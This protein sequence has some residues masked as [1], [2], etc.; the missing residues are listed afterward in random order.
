MKLNQGI[1]SITLKKHNRL[2]D[3]TFYDII[4]KFYDIIL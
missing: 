2:Y 1:C 4:S 3:I